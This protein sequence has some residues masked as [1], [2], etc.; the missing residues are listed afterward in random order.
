MLKI[1]KSTVVLMTCVLVEVLWAN[2]ETLPAAGIRSAPTPTVKFQLPADCA[3]DVDRL[4]FSKSGRSICAWWWPHRK[5]G[6][7][8][9]EPVDFVVIDMNGNLVGSSSVTNRNELLRDFPVIAWRE[10]WK[11]FVK[12]AVGWGFAADFS[13]GLRIQTTGDVWWPYVAEMWDLTDPPRLMWKTPIPPVAVKPQMVEL[14]QETNTGAVLVAVNGKEIIDLDSQTGEIKRRF[15]TGPIESD[16]EAV[17]RK[18][19]F[20]L[21]VDDG[22]PSLKFSSYAVG[23]DSKTGLLACGA[24]FD[25]RMR[26]VQVSS[27]NR[28]LFEANTDG[29]PAL[30]KGGCWTVR[31]VEFQNG[32]KYLLAESHFGGRGTDVVLDP[33]EIFETSTWKIVWREDET[34]IRAVT[35]SQDGNLLAFLRGNVIEV[36]PFQPAIEKGGRP[37]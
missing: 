33:T 36:Y 25:K 3:N 13:T 16:S 12:D 26:V 6:D 7:Y 10:K 21:K 11:D 2:G 30:P 24:F 17:K 31:R 18:K 4:S 14:L 15:T 35:L 9:K 28:I 34:S 29:H 5:S 19:H 32:G 1:W 8:N 20:R 23:Y 22:D 37:N 27:P